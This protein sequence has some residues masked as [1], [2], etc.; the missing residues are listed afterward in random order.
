MPFI[1]RVLIATT[2]VHVFIYTPYMNQLIKQVNQICF[3]YQKRNSCSYWLFVTENNVSLKVGTWVGGKALPCTV[4]AFDMEAF[5]S[6]NLIS[7]K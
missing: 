4:L 3:K 1:L 7:T 6:Q 5:V 2:M